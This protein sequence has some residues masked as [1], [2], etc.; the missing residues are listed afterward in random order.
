MA[1]KEVSYVGIGNMKR[2]YDRQTLGSVLMKD[3]P[4]YY[5]FFYRNLMVY[6]IFDLIQN[7]HFANFRMKKFL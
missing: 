2:L 5:A 6:N 7:I 1:E 4:K 3:D